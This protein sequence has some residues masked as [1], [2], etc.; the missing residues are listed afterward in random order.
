MKNRL[1]LFATLFT[2]AVAQAFAA[3]LPQSGA[4]GLLG[5]GA[6]AILVTAVAA[7]GNL[8]RLC[9]APRAAPTAQL[10]VYGSSIPRLLASSVFLWLGLSLQ[11]ATPLLPWLTCSKTVDD[12]EGPTTTTV[13]G[14]AFFYTRCFYGTYGPP[15][16]TYSSLV[17]EANVIS[18][19]NVGTGATNAVDA[20]RALS[21]GVTSLLFSAGLLLP[22]AI[23]GSVALCLLRRSATSGAPPY[24]SGCAPGSLCVAQA[25][26]WSGF[27]VCSI[28]WWSALSLCS[29]IAKN[30]RAT[31]GVNELCPSGF[32]YAS[33][34]GAIAAGASFALLLVGLALMA[35]VAESVKGVRGVGCTGGGCVRLA[36]DD[37]SGAHDVP[38][39]STES[40]RLLVQPA[41]VPKF[42][43]SY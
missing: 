6:L 20:S 29:T 9:G 33:T 7:F 18:Y 22:C 28:V 5:F 27:A 1:A 21:L 30:L 19:Y 11:L 17:G 35:S 25:L 14:N 10:P 4:A 38:L 36:L 2:C 43:S 3:Y 12:F 41:P 34:P 23:M 15:S 32:A 31:P 40:S 39:A 16:C 26:G 42:A 24:S 8:E 37:G 13:T